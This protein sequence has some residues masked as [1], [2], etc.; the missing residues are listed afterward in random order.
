MKQISNKGSYA[1]LFGGDDVDVIVKKL[2][3]HK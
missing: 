2:S 3:T 1:D